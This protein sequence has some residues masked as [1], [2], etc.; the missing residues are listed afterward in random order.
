MSV[1]RSLGRVHRRADINLDGFGFPMVLPPTPIRL[2]GNN[3]QHHMRLEL[4]RVTLRTT[5]AVPVHGFHRMF[6]LLTVRF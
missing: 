1:R 5:L 3:F 2:G 6:V 4:T